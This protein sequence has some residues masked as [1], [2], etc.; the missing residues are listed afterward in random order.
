MERIRTSAERRGVV[1]PE[2]ARERDHVAKYMWKALRKLVGGYLQ[3]YKAH[4][5]YRLRYRSLLASYIAEQK[6]D[7][8]PRH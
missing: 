1:Q 8:P 5:D 7:P 4:N 2:E 6:E 3:E